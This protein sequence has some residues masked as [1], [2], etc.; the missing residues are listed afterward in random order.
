MRVPLNLL[1][2][3]DLCPRCNICS[4]SFKMDAILNR[5]A[6]GTI[7]RESAALTLPIALVHKDHW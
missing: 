6:G 3:L 7:H 5:K 2:V 4:E 1:Q